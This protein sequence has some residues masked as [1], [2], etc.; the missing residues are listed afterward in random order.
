MMA[1]SQAL[2]VL[3]VK[4]K[5]LLVIPKHSY[6]FRTIGNMNFWLMTSGIVLVLMKISLK[7]APTMKKG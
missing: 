6:A 5:V 7:L 2:G 4:W 3:G 1:T